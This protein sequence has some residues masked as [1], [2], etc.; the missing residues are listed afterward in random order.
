MSDRY[1]A[2]LNE[3]LIATLR[4]AMKTSPSSSTAATR[5]WQTSPCSKT[6]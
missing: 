5:A 3:N 1:L 6:N 4:G 2:R